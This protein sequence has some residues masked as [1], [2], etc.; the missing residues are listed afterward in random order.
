M[1]NVWHLKKYDDGSVFGPVNVETLRGWASKGEISPY[2]ML[3][4]DGVKWMAA[5]ELDALEMNWIVEFPDGEAYGPT[6]IEAIRSFVT[7]GQLS[8]E[9]S[10]RDATTG[11]KCPIAEHPAF[12][13]MEWTAGNPEESAEPTEPAAEDPSQALG[14]AQ[15][16]IEYLHSR[17]A[18]LEE[19]NE[20]MQA[21]HETTMAHLNQELVTAKTQQQFLRSELDLLKEAARTEQAAKG[22]SEKEIAAELERIREQFNI[23]FE[24]N[25]QL[26]HNYEES[27]AQLNRKIQ[28]TLAKIEENAVREAELNRQ[29]ADAAHREAQYREQIVSMEKELVKAEQAHA[30]LLEEYGGLNERLMKFLNKSGA[31]TEPEPPTAERKPR[32][33]K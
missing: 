8:G 14:A 9:N 13:D 25:K 30:K 15:D 21:A 23:L 3:S 2:D 33:K 6:C 19:T 26:T 27:L 7:D 12:Q 32:Q 24:I 4:S 29:V 31:P 16:E 5:P 28:D 10:I 1:D 22:S 18:E 17:V 20:K 11:E